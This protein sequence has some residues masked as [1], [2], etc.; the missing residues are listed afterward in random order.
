[1]HKPAPKG[2]TSNLMIKKIIPL[3]VVCLA[4]FGT[5]QALDDAKPFNTF[6]HREV[7]RMACIGDSITQADAYVSA[8]RTALGKQWE[9]TNFGVS[10]ATMLKKGDNPYNRLGQYG[11]AM[12]K[13]PDV[14][15]IMLGT[16]DSKPGNWAHK[17][18]FEADYK[19]VIADLKKANPKVV[20]YCCVPPPAGGNKWGINGE[21]IKNEI[22]PMVRKLAKETNCYVIDLQEPLTGKNCIPDGVH[23][24]VDGH[25]L[26]AAAI[27]KA[28][29]GKPIPAAAPAH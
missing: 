24:N 1:M 20:I 6:G 27:Y 19:A 8:L 18:E 26:M 16:N 7:I 2:K 25:K 13:K 11:Q 28:L 14:A 3:L 29:T 5:V 21:V 23:P 22:Q 17:A 4:F 15:T 12:Q 9:V 10:G